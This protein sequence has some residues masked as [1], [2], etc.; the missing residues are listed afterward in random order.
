MIN[1]SEVINE[2]I[3]LHD[4]G[5]YKEA[6]AEYKK[7]SRSDT[8]YVRALYEMAY[9]SYADSQFTAANEYCELALS[10]KEDRERE[11]VLYAQYANTIDELGD[12]NRALRIFDSAIQKYPA[13]GQLY[14][15]KGETLLSLEKYK[16]AEEL[17]KTALLID[18]YNYSVHFRL[19]QAAINQGKIVQA[20]MSLIAY[21]M[22]NPGGRYQQTAVSLM[23]MIAKN[24]TGL[25]ELINK[26]TEQP[27]DLMQLLEQIILS[28]IALDKNYKPLTKL[29]DNIVR[30]IQVLFEKMEYSESDTD[31]WIQYYVPL[32]KQIFTEGKFEV[33]VNHCFSEM[34]IDM[35]N[36]FTKKNKKETE[37]LITEIV[38]Y[39]NTIR[40][41]RMLNYEDRS[42]AQPL[43][44]FS[45]GQLSSKGK[46]ST[47]SEKTIGEWEYYYAEGNIRARGSY[48]DKGERKGEWRYYNFDGTLSAT[49]NYKD[50]LLEGKAINYFRNSNIKSSGSYS[51][52]K[53]TG[54]HNSYYYSG[55]V[56]EVSNYTNGKLN[57]IKKL[58]F[59]NG[60]IQAI[61]TYKEDSLDGNYKSYFK[62]GQL[63][64]ELSYVN[65][66]AAGKT[67]GYL[68]NG[69]TDFE[70]Q[71]ENNERAGTWKRYH[72]NGKLKSTEIYVNGLLEGPYEE[73]Y[74]NG[75]LFARYQNKKGKVTGNAE[76]FDEDGKLFSIFSYENDILKS[77]S[78]F[79]KSGKEIS[80]SDTKNKILDLAFYRPDGTKRRQAVFNNKG[81][82][83]GA[84]TF[85]YSIGQI[86]ETNN[87]TDGQLN[88]MSKAYHP[89]GKL[90]TELSYLNGKKDGYCKTYY[91]HGTSKSEGWYKDDKAEAMWYYYDEQGNTTTQVNYLNE[92]EHGYRT[93]YW[94]S[95]KPDLEQK[96]YYGWLEE[97]TQYDTSGK[98]LNKITF[99]KGSGKYTLLNFNDKVYGEGN[100]VNNEFNGPFRYYYFDGSLQSEQ[101]FKNGENE[102][103]FKNYAYGGQ[104]S[105]EGE[106]KSGK[107]TGTW[108]YY[109]P[110]GKLIHTEQYADGELNGPKIYYSDDSNP[111][112][113]TYYKD[114]V[115]DS[116][117][118]SY[119]ENGKLI[120]I[121][122]FH[123]DIP[124]SY[125]YFDKNGKLVP[126]IEIPLGTGEVKA[127]HSNGNLAA[128][129]KYYDGKVNGIEK[130]YYSNGKP[131]DESS[132]E[133]GATEGPFKGYYPDG[134]LK[135]E[136]VYS[137][138]NAHGPYKL[139]NSKG[140]ITEEGNYYNGAQHGTVKLYD[141]NGTLKQ[142]LYY[143]YGRLLSVKK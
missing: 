19:G 32:L 11:P 86:S 71:Y 18:P 55:S 101:N 58:F 83:T 77:A 31:F 80:K 60:N 8:N 65:G 84:E 41:T 81:I 114:G 57:G 70:G 130:N 35:I 99:P 73:Y 10:L 113:V 45:E 64:S 72:P 89:N 106:Y 46:L 108:K 134:K 34:N 93:E 44:F 94:P 3:K 124:L 133:Y 15:N 68:E 27:S 40:S 102:G 74:D 53:E 110:N 75:V 79:D 7:V 126:S 76:Y 16:E 142:T 50:G 139:Y 67:K 119:D 61:E 90:S 23:K 59:G 118:N 21:Q 48:D 138:D 121:T 2:G 123:D 132:V 26:R 140:I 127:Y 116:V 56:K 24:E 20:F 4:Q 129:F 9:T 17:F 62:N 29:D 51:S 136:Y 107:K 52:D 96:S 54:E 122:Y 63:A 82:Q 78:Y 141:D 49:E 137:H 42:K 6:I 128:E 66:K 100:Y 25:E 117:S 33:F 105:A 22:M 104:L 109:K 5:K 88:G 1:S 85:F 112:R 69:Q 98:V 143:Y 91:L 125:T 12:K 120:F 131:E 39:S 43:Y 47:D 13:F 28:K 37:A 36:S 115:R 87:Y 14:L 97:M 30:Q 111:L 95:G 135:F 103:L 92:E 38:T